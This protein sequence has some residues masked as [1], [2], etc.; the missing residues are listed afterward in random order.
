MQGDT[1]GAIVCYQM[2]LRLDPGLRIAR[3]NLVSLLVHSGRGQSDESLRLC[4]EELLSGPQGQVWLRRLASTAMARRD[5]TLA[6]EYAAI[7]AALRWGSDWYPRRAEG[8]LPRL[9]IEPDQVF[10]TIPK[11]MHDIE[12]FR[13]LSEKL[14]CLEMN[15]P[16]SI[17]ASY[18]EV[19]ARLS[20]PGMP[21]RLP[22][23][24]ELQ[25]MIGHVF[26][27]IVH[28]RHTPR[29]DRALSTAWDAAYSRTQVSP[30]NRRGWWSSTT[31]CLKARWK[32]CVSSRLLG[33]T[34][35]SGNRYAPRAPWRL[36]PRWV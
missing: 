12:Q 31:S 22:L 5:L 11:L 7:L 25:E 23:E 10:V 8:V 36:L 9:P 14:A 27:R 6:G 20:E 33:S 28:V 32:T 19:T 16:R 21:P 35:W 17:S 2:A 15:S 18:Q 4:A 30:T 34:V 3:R 29:M 13:Y 26:N 1:D 24:G